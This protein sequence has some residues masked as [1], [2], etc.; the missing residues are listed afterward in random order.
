MRLQLM[1]NV[2]RRFGHHLG[3]YPVFSNHRYLWSTPFVG[4]A[5]RANRLSEAATFRYFL[6]IMTFD[7]LQFTAIGTTPTP[8]I[9]P[10]SL[11]G[12]WATFAITVLGLLY[13]YRKNGGGSGRRFLSRYFPLSITVGWKFVG[14]MFGILWLVPVVL[15]GRSAEFLGWSSSITLSVVNVAM[16]WR[17]GTHLEAL[18]RN[19]TT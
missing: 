11:A 16:F 12:S 18:A 5:L 14:A 19:T 6:A 1:L 8:S 13:L 3:D 2:R 17:I 10:W 9:A 15:A 7:W 4:E